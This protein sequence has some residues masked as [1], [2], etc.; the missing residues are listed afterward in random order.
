MNLCMIHDQSFCNVAWTMEKNCVICAL[1]VQSSA[2]ETCT[3]TDKYICINKYM[4]L[5]FL[6]NALFR[7]PVSLLCCLF[8]MSSI[9]KD[10]V[11]VNYMY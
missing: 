8:D 9:H 10:I 2:I 7:T 6:C 4:E 11:M 1:G 5:K 3:R